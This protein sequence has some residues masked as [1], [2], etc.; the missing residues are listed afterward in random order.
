MRVAIRLTSGPAAEEAVISLDEIRTGLER[1]MLRAIE[2]WD[3]EKKRLAEAVSRAEAKEREFRE[4]A[5]EVRR[6]FEAIDLVTE[7][8]GQTE[9]RA[10]I[11][12]PAPAADEKPP[13]NEKTMRPVSQ[14]LL[15]SQ[16]RAELSPILR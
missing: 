5:E 13:A 6:R 10:P 2:S 9:P 7:M 8:A 4:I 16:L 11:S 14:P 12:L 1:K 15:T 3:V